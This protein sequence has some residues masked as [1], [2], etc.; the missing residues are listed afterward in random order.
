MKKMKLCTVCREY[1]LER[2]HCERSTIS[3]HPPPFN[4]NDPY[5][6]YRRKHKGYQGVAL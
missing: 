1:T 5:G 2:K 6:D 3:A 4:P